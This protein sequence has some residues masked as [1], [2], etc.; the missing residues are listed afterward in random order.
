MQE[1]SEGGRSGLSDR[2]R[3]RHWSIARA[4]PF[5]DI[6]NEKGGRSLPP[7]TARLRQSVT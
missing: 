3:A 5:L 4:A 1:I 7:V 6:D 2:R